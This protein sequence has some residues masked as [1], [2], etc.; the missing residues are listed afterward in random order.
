MLRLPV[1]SRRGLLQ[2]L[3][4]K[5][6]HANINSI[7]SRSISSTNIS[8]NVEAFEAAKIS[9]YADLEDVGT[10]NPKGR[11]VYQNRKTDMLTINQSINARL[12]EISRN[13]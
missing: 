4:S 10:K 8:C 2:R 5:S 11:Y 9:G 3:S 6:I 7:I 12:S 13:P 1:C